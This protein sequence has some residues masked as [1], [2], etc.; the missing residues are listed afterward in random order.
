MECSKADA[1]FEVTIEQFI[2]CV[3]SGTS[4]EQPGGSRAKPATLFVCHIPD[5][6]KYRNWGSKPFPGNKTYVS[7]YG[8]LNGVVDRPEQ[9]LIGVENIS[10]CGQ[11]IP[12]VP[13]APPNPHGCECTNFLTLVAE[14][15]YSSCQEAR[16]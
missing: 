2:S 1:T 12:P 16:Q 6:P 8:F 9:F 13:A 7:V 14:I 10:F 11:Y 3:K 15:L 4:T 5:S